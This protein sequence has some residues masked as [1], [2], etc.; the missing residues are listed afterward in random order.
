MSLQLY[1]T[2]KAINIFIKTDTHTYHA[3]N[4]STSYSERKCENVFI[5]NVIY[6]AQGSTLLLNQS[7]GEYNYTLQKVLRKVQ[8]ENNFYSEVCTRMTY[9]V[10]SQCWLSNF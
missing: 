10:A 4:Y 9:Y 1:I 2:N 7:I 6:K 8:T 3:L 5:K